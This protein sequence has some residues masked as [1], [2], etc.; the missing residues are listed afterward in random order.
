M[1][2]LIHKTLLP[3]ALLL[4]L[5]LNASANARGDINGD[6]KITISDVPALIDRLLTNDDY[7]P[8]YDTNRDGVFSISDVTELIDY[9]LTG[10]WQSGY[11]VPDN[12]EF[13]TV[14]G[15]T[16][17]MVPVEGGTFMMGDRHAAGAHYPHLVELSSFKI[18]LT[19]VTQELWEA[20]MG[21]NPSYTIGA[22]RPVNYVTW[23]QCMDFTARLRELTGVN[24]QLPTDAQWEF[25]ARGGNLSQGYYYSGSDNIDDVAWYNIQINGSPSG[26]SM[27]PVGQK[28][29][30]ELGI[31]DMSG[32]AWEWCYDYFHIIYEHLVQPLEIDPVYYYDTPNPRNLQR[33]A[34]AGG[35]AGSEFS[36]YGRRAQYPSIAWDGDGLRLAIWP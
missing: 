31:Y 24:F 4:V 18:G 7:M 19:E 30:N 10:S 15:V 8:H 16:F 2:T 27:H 25:A 3:L 11:V 22:D 23:Y 12:A 33:G 13:Y 5:P 29:P 34:S 26:S 28:D 17:A 36:V 1:K 32:N 20:V 9:L 35:S 14:N 6:S 21:E